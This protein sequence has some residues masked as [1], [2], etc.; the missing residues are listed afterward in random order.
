MKI[1]LNYEF[2]EINERNEVLMFLQSMEK[3]DR[4]KVFAYFYKVL[5]IL[6]L[7]RIPK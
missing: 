1:D 3:N 4:A 2:A 6:N 5:E 7:G